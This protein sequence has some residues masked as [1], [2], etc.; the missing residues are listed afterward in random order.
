MNPEECKTP[1]L[2]IKEIR[3]G[4]EQSSHILGLRWEHVKETLLD[5]RWV[6]RPIDKALTHQNILS[7]VSSVFDP[8]GL[9]APYTA[10]F[11]FI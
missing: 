4:S 3:N 9:L 7:F 6:D 10:L 11:K 2:P 5:S 8:V 1:S